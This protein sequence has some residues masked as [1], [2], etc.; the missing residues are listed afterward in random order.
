M[1]TFGIFGIP[2]HP[3]ASCFVVVPST[4]VTPFRYTLLLSGCVL[5]ECLHLVKIPIT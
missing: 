2:P 3:L 5:A 4:N 1:L